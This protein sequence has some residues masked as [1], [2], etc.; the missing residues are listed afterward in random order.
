MEVP[1]SIPEGSELLLNG[2][3]SLSFDFRIV[4]YEWDL[5][6]DELT[7]LASEEPW[8]TTSYPDDGAVLVTLLV[9]D[10]SGLTGMT[11]NTITVTNV[12]PSD[13]SIATGGEFVE[14]TEIAFSGDAF[15]PGADAL[16]Y[17]WDFGD[18]A[19]AEGKEVTHAYQDEGSYEVTLTVFDDDGG[20]W[21]HGDDGG[22]RICGRDGS[23]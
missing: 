10:E 11:N 22:H 17:R 4:R 12:S 15:D 23:L 20:D 14:D 13:L 3:T 9:E 19:E 21:L 16:T 1:S 5:D 7:D 18:G 2:S 8:T 6:G